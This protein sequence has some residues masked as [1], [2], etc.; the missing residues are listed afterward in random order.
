MNANGELINVPLIL[1]V[2]IHPAAIHARVI[3]VSLE[4]VDDVLI[5]TSVKTK[6]NVATTQIAKILSEVIDVCNNQ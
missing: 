4:M 3:P 1:F 6:T 2:K 5:S